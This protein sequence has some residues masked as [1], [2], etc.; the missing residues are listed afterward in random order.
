MKG[1][2]QQGMG[3]FGFIIMLCILGFLAFLA[4][5][6]LPA[7]FN[8]QK[9][10]QALDSIAEHRIVAPQDE[11][12]Q[13][14]NNIRNYMAKMFRV[15]NVEDVPLENIKVDRVENYYLVTVN[16]EVRRTVLANVDVLISFQDSTKVIP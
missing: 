15:D 14:T 16:Y 4:W 6:I 12:P 7:Y 3:T 8:N 2:Q 11:L 9:V 5:Q 1:N 10:K 13:A